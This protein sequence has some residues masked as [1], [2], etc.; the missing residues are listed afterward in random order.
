MDGFGKFRDVYHAYGVMEQ[1]CNSLE[2]GCDECRYALIS[3][4]SDV[5]CCFFWIMENVLD[6]KVEPPKDSNLSETEMLARKGDSLTERVMASLNALMDLESGRKPNESLS[7]FQKRRTE[8]MRRADSV[9][10]DI[11]EQFHGGK[12]HYEDD[13]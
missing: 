1:F 7:D 12:N 2:N 13:D 11:E 6:R 8:T 10:G 4:M 5:P 3:E 9:V